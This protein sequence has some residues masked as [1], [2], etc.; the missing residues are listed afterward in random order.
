MAT[1]S[2]KEKVCFKRTKLR[3]ICSKYMSCNAKQMAHFT[4]FS[5]KSASEQNGVHSTQLQQTEQQMSSCSQLVATL[6]DRASAEWEWPPSRRAA[7]STGLPARRPR[8]RERRR[9][10]RLCAPPRAN[11]AFRCGRVS[12]SRDTAGPMRWRRAALFL[13]YSII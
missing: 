11:R 9:D 7:A 6:N 13:Q 3:E 5:R 12:A 1:N 8:R 4:V 2:R 10:A